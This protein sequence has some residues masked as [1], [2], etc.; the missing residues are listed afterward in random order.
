MKETILNALK[1][2]EE[3]YNVKILFACESGS[4][5]WGFPSRD[6][7]YDVRFIYIHKKED[8]LAIDPMGI[9]TKRDVIELP[10]NESLDISGWDLT[11]TLRLFRK[12]NPP[13][14]EWL[15]SGIVY[16]QAFTTIEKMQVLSKSVFS[17]VF[18]LHHY[19]NM[20]NNNFQT[21]IKAEK[22]KIKKYFY[23]LR[24]LLAAKWIETY[25]EFPPLEFPTLLSTLLPQGELEKEIQSLLKRKKAGE[26]FDI[27]PNIQII[28]NFVSEEIP[29][30]REFTKTIKKDRQDFTPALDDLFR[31]TLD[32]VWNLQ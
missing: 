18:C 13:L 16:Y 26:E 27:E 28:N 31:H 1:K 11:K 23:V 2:V 24:P 4:R 5:A 8:Y 29:R 12:S 30:L 32:E 21:Y 10:I 15:N 9:G 22:I 7:D 3:D 19:L 17:P 25:N 6:S 20:A 14:M